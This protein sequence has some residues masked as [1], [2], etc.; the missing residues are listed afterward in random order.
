MNSYLWNITD[1]EDFYRL[2]PNSTLQDVLVETKRA[3]RSKYPWPE[4]RGR[5]AWAQSPEKC[6]NGQLTV[7]I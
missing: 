2:P 7:S 3:D 4:L 1:E 5:T 6:N